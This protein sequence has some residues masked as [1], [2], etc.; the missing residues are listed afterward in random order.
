MAIPVHALPLVQGLPPLLVRQSSL[1]LTTTPPR[2]LASVAIVCPVGVFLLSL[3]S[4]VIF[5]GV[6][7]SLGK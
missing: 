3:C 5:G 2:L 1:A 6:P 7:R 4:L